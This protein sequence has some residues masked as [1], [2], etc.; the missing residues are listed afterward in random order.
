MSPENVEFIRRLY[1]AVNTAGLGAA[2]DFAHPE[3]EVVPPPI[4]P[5]AS[6]VKG[7]ESVQEWARQWMETFDSF[8]AEPKRYLEAGGER[9]VVYVRDTGRIKGSGAEIDAQL[10]H[11][12]T[13]R[14]GKIIRWEIFTDEAQALD[15]AGLTA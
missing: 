5:E 14:D 11:V 9:V 15:A 7:L 3:I 4:W 12:W 10:V 13:L 8:R 6:G 2:V 1:E